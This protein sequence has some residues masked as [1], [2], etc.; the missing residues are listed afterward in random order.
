MCVKTARI[1]L[2]E[3]ANFLDFGI[4]HVTEGK[5]DGTKTAGYWHGAYRTFL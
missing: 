5:I 3:H 4:G 1:V 2:G